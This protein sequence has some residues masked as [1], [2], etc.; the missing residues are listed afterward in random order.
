MDDEL[1][2]SLFLYSWYLCPNGYP[3]ATIN[4]KRVYLHR[5]LFEQ[6][7]NNLVVDHI[8]GNILDN[9]KCNLRLCTTR[10]NIINSKPQKNKRY[11]KYKGVS[12][13]STENRRKRWVAACE[14]YGKRVTIGRFHT[15][16]E[17]AEAYN[18]KAYELFGEYA[19]LNKIEN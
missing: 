8:N 4:K 6:I 9:R 19:K 7:D 13:C 2:D 15:E 3:R 10:Q 18:K 17:A 12:Y 16:K 1:F 5:Y 11:S 14:V